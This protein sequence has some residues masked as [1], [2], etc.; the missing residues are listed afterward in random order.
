MS[1]AAPI[2]RRFAQLDVFADRPQRGNPLAV[3]LDAQ[4]LTEEEMQRVARWTNLSETTFLLPPIS[5]EA[6]YRV[7]IFTPSGELPFAGHPTLGTARAWLEAGGIPAGERIVQE[8]AAGLITVRRDGGRLAFAAPALLR[9]GPLDE[10]DVDQ[11][12]SALGVTR[13]SVL[14]HAWVDNG[15][16]WRVLELESADQVLSLSPDLAGMTDAKLGVVGRHGSAGA[17]AGP[18]DGTAGPLYEVRAFTLGG[19]EDPVTGSLNA[20]IAQWMVVR[21]PMPTR[22][23]AAQGTALGREGRIDVQV[24][25]EG[26]IWIGGATVLTVEGSILV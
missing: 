18:A 11:L 25:A 2:A 10:A 15:P 19:V 17:A 7:R 16:G 13:S 6:D 12:A 20:G 1:P 21:E 8:C 5:T 3:V 26:T 24:A 22:W 9:S 14:G 23:T 4:G